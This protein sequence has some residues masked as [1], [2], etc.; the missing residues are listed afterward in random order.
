MKRGRTG[1][2]ARS[3]PRDDDDDA[4][5]FAAK[6]SRYGELLQPGWCQQEASLAR[7]GG[8]HGA[9]RAQAPTAAGPSPH[10][11]SPHCLTVTKSSAHPHAMSYRFM[12]AMRHVLEAHVLP[13]GES[14]DLRQVSPPMHR[15]LHLFHEV[16]QAQ[17]TFEIAADTMEEAWYQLRRAIR[18]QQTAIAALRVRPTRRGL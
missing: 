2:A 10:C 17:Q 13:A 11:L 7:G 9:G 3:T 6:L 8:G 15:L 12:A 4:C 18:A 1:G 16:L 14:V 5:P